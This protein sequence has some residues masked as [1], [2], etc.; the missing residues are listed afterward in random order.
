VRVRDARGKE[1]GG[2]TQVRLNRIELVLTLNDLVDYIQIDLL[3]D[4][5]RQLAASSSE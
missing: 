1:S 3:L 2:R 5:L 4:D